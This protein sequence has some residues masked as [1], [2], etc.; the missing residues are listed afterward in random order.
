MAEQVELLAQFSAQFAAQAEQI[1]RLTAQGEQLTVQ[2]NC[3]GDQFRALE[4]T[5]FLDWIRNVVTS[6]LLVL[7]G[8]TFL[9]R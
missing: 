1:A 8:D 5:V 3:Q 7:A 6:I 4:G 2:L 9:I